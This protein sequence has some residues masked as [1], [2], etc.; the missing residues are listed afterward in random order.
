MAHLNRN[1]IETILSVPGI[2]GYKGPHMPYTPLLRPYM[3]ALSPHLICL[4]AGMNMPLGPASGSG[5]GF[6]WP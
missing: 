2:Q 4:Y 6:S 3:R 1:K 5:L